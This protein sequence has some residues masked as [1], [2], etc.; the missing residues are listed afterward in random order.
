MH[1]PSNIFIGSTLIGVAYSM[2]LIPQYLKDLEK[3]KKNESYNISVCED[4]YVTVSEILI[5][6]VITTSFIYGVYKV[7]FSGTNN[8]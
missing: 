8:L 5:S 6:P 1:Y 3:K 2:Y 7:M 4:N